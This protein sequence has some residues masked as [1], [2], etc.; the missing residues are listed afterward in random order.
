MKVFLLLPLYF[1]S[2][3]CPQTETDVIIQKDNSL[4]EVRILAPKEE[5]EKYRKITI[6]DSEGLKILLP[7]EIKG[8]I[9]NEQAFISFESSTTKARESL[10]AQILLE[11]EISLLKS[12]PQK[13]T[14]IYLFKKKSE[15]VFHEVSYNTQK[16]QAA[17]FTPHDNG[18]ASMRIKT[19]STDYQ[20]F[21]MRY[22]G[23]NPEVKMQIVSRAL[24]MADLEE[25]CELYNQ[26]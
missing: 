25:I 26:Y 16:D 7:H 4:V 11:G 13:N 3:L 17:M 2:F 6:Q 23:E 12:V 15:T 20:A 1:L 19:K 18:E 10:F 8:F 24:S 21:L 9:L 5:N 14:T 22:F